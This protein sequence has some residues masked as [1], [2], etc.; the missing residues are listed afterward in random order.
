MA[1]ITEQLLRSPEVAGS[2]VD[3]A[4]LV[5][6]LRAGDEGAFVILVN[7]HQSSMI[8]VAEIYVSSRATAEDVVQETLLAVL[9]GV[10]RFENRSTLKTWMF[11]ILTNR[12]KTAGIR[13]RRCQ[14][15]ECRVTRDVRPSGSS[16]RHARRTHV[17][18]G[19][20]QWLVNSRGHPA[21]EMVV[22][23]EA[24]R[25]AYAAIGQLPKMQ[26]LVVSL[27]DGEGWSAHE[28]CRLLD[29]SETNQRVL[30]HR[31]RAAVR[32]RLANFYLPDLVGS[33]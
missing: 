12:A 4:R 25:I 7:R 20:D 26:R 19:A 9:E 3:D 1:H 13:E 30:L 18:D 27:R 11:R 31:G 21:D 8:L 33:R 16:D 17:A 32:D 29:L 10:D 28:V 6:R 24:M 22:S 2:S 14:P 5:E 23:A 15:D